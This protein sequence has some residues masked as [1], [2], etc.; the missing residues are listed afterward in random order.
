MI[1]AARASHRTLYVLGRAAGL[2]PS[3]SFLCHADLRYPA[4]NEEPV[5]AYRRH[6]TVPIV[7]GA[8]AIADRSRLRLREQPMTQTVSTRRC[9]RSLSN[10]VRS[11]VTRC[12]AE[13]RLALS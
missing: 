8:R 5:L 6:P 12:E 3:V 11:F 2:R 9:P 10:A 7:A 4:G 13:A 1:R